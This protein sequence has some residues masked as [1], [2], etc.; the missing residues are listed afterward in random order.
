MDQL[1]PGVTGFNFTTRLS[2]RNNRALDA[3]KVRAGIGSISTIA[4]R[5]GGMEGKP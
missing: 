2:I 4:R 1:E 3:I 5:W